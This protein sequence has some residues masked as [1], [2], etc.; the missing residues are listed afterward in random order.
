MSDSLHELGHVV[1][2][3]DLVQPHGDGGGEKQLLGREL[4]AQVPQQFDECRLQTKSSLTLDALLNSC[5]EI[6]RNLRS[7]RRHRITK[8]CFANY[9]AFCFYYKQIGS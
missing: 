4:L 6:F 5:E 8:H 3:L 9:K 7:I 2:G 1:P